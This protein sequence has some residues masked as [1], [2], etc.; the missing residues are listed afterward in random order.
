M[1]Y[2]FKT[3]KKK[4]YVINLD[5]PFELLAVEEYSRKNYC[6]CM[7]KWNWRLNQETLTKIKCLLI[8][9]SALWEQNLASNCFALFLLPTDWFFL[10]FLFRRLT[11]I[12]ALD[13]D[14]NRNCCVSGESFLTGICTTFSSLGGAGLSGHNR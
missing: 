10:S 4:N 5:F 11:Q 13:S 7:A 6:I 2:F 12:T 14:Y 3:F 8:F 9:L 1:N